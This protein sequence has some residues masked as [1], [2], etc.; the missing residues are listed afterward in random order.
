MIQPRM[1]ALLTYSSIGSGVRRG[2]DWGVKQPPL[3]LWKKERRKKR[4]KG[5]ERKGEKRGEKGKIDRSIPIR[6][7]LG[8]K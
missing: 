1:G 2:V 5:E 3:Q 7:S 6:G 4:G 8:N